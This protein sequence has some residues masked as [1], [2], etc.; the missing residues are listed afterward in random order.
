MLVLVQTVLAEI[1]TE[2]L[3]IIL[4]AVDQEELEMALELMVQ[5]DM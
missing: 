3:E 4:V 2:I 5:E 1:I